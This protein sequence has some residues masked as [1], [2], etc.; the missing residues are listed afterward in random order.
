M[1][2][3]RS[4]FVGGGTFFASLGR[5]V[6]P[7]RG[8]CALFEG[9]ALHGGEPIVQG[10]RYIL[11]AFLYLD[12][13]SGDDANPQLLQPVC[14]DDADSPCPWEENGPR[15]KKPRLFGEASEKAPAFSFGFFS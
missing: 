14:V 9:R 12:R 1:L 4:E 11:A 3:S 15:P 13:R 5:A 8:H 2:S 7:P 6:S 10:T